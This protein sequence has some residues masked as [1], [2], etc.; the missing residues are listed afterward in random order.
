MLL[1]SLEDKQIV[2]AATKHEKIASRFS[3]LEL[4][5]ATWI[6]FRFI[7]GFLD[8]PESTAQNPG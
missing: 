3:G 8:K 7:C 1:A 5:G 6:N 2:N 4:S